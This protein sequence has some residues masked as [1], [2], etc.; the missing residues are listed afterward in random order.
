MRATA[1]AQLAPD[2]RAEKI[3][4][5]YHPDQRA[6]AYKAFVAPATVNLGSAENMLL[7][8]YLQQNAFSNLPTLTSVTARYPIA[9]PNGQPYNGGSDATIDSIASFLSTQWKLKT[10]INPDNIYG[11]SGVI[12]AL[13]VVALVLFSPGQQVITPAPTFYGFP[14]SFSQKT[15]SLQFNTFPIQNE[16]TLTL[17]DVQAA[18]KQYPNAKLL[19]L[20]NPNNPIGTNY[21]KDLLEQI[22]ALWLSDSSRHILSDEIYACSQASTNTFVSALSLDAYKKYPNQIHVTWGLSKDFGLAG[23]RAGFIISQN[24]TI[25]QA[26][27]GGQCGPIPSW[28]ASEAWFAPLVNLNPYVMQRVFLNSSGGADPTLANQS[29]TE[30]HGLL[31][32]QYNG[33]AQLLKDGGIPYATPNTGALFFWIDLSKYLDKVPK[34]TTP[35]PP[36]CK[37][38]Y[39]HDD[40]REARLGAYI[41]NNGLILIRGQECFNTAPGRFRLCYTADTMEQVTIGIKAMIAALQKLG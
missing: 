24:P 26:L 37:N 18:L 2:E 27:G 41:Q 6:A 29:M 23:F 16:L 13:E 10:Q 19:V 1:Y 22:Y 30:Y 7:L 17:G 32:K 36:L 11:S 39:S 14:W 4:T 38:L 8:P 40:V 25:A 15:A 3:S 34:D 12:A 20:C 28:Y 35:W 9:A 33:T 21:S 31:Q 5:I